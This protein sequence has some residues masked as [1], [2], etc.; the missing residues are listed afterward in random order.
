MRRCHICP[1]HLHAESYTCGGVPTRFCQRCRQGH[2]LVDFDG[3]KHCCC[4]SLERCKQ[5]RRQRREA[6]A[7]R[8]GLELPALEQPPLAMPPP[9]PGWC[10]VPWQ[11]LA[12]H[13]P[14]LLPAALPA[15]P[16]PGLPNN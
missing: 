12:A 16:L 3:A 6:Q 2:A 5:L 9:R 1:A 14:E 4:R 8:A 15:G 13:A 10:L 7:P 11:A